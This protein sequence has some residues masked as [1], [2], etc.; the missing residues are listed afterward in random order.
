ML[1][2]QATPAETPLETVELGRTGLHVSPLGLGTWAWGDRMMWGYGQGYGEGDVAQAF[3]TTLAAGVNFFDTAE[4][5]GSGQSERYLGQ[6]V[7]QT[8]RRLVTVA[9][10][11]LPLPWR[12]SRNSLLAALRASLARLQMDYVDLYQIH[13]PLPPVS[14]EA[15]MEALGDAVEQGLTRTVGVS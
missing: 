10:K 9:T 5:Y 13:F 12:V 8:Q 14:V 1:E 11:F 3:R 2:M 4:I 6:F 7:R 15:R